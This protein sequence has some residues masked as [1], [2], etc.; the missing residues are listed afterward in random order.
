MK[1]T[2]MQT[3]SPQPSGPKEEQAKLPEVEISI[4]MPFRNVGSHIR[5][6][7]EALDGQT[8]PGVWELVAVDNASTDAS[9]QIAEEFVD[10]LPLRI[11]DAG[12]KANLSYA[13]NAGARAATGRGLIFLDADDVA[14]PDYLAAMAKGLS[15]HAFVT[16]RLD[17]LRLNPEW[18]QQAF[19][20][21]HHQTEI[22]PFPGFLPFAGGGIGVSREAFETVG[23]FSEELSGAEDIAFSWDVQLTG[24]PLHFVPEALLHYRHR[25]SLGGLYR[26][27]RK[28]GRVLPLLYQRYRDAGMPGKPLEAGLREWVGLLRELPRARTRARLAPLIMRLGYCVGRMEGSLRHRTLYL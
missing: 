15:C 2:D 12:E 18:V 7:L 21:P 1:M 8:Y 16:P 9:R 19:G 27:T 13:R 22:H 4:V 28:W 23:G 11:V 14:A 5:E 25:S 3:N 26:Q 6:Q 10:R 20:G 17:S 24:V